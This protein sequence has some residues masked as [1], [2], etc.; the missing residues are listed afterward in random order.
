[1]F[2]FPQSGGYPGVASGVESASHLNRSAAVCPSH[3]EGTTM[4]RL[5]VLATVLAMAA[6]AADAKSCKD[7]KG[8]FT[9]CPP[10]AAISSAPMASGGSTKAPKHCVKGKACGDSCIAMKDVCHK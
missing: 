3:R 1:M 5:I 10:A 2:R 4:R 9:K 8:K 7:A 6:G